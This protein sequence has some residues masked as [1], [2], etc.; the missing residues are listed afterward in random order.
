MPSKYS[1]NSVARFA[2]P[3]NGAVQHVAEGSDGEKRDSRVEMTTERREPGRERKTQ[4]ERS[5]LIGGYAC[6]V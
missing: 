4:S 5:D 6:A 2:P 1:P 3:R